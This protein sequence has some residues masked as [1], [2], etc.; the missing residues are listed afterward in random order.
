M[1]DGS[2][3][4]LEIA[5]VSEDEAEHSQEDVEAPSSYHPS[6]DRLERQV[7]RRSSFCTSRSASAGK[8][9]SGLPLIPILASDNEGIPGGRVSYVLLSPHLQDNSVA[10]SRKRRR[11]LKAIMH[12]PSRSK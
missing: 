11:S 2:G 1:P 9:A 12:E 6:S 8:A 3:V 7:A 5:G 10:V 4:A